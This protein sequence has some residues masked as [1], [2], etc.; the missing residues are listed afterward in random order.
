MHI[1]QDLSQSMQTSPV[2]F[3][4]YAHR[5]DAYHDGAITKLREELSNAIGVAIGEDF[6]I[7]QDRKDIAW[8]EHWP[9]KLEQGL[10]GC[11]FLIPI[12][13]PSFFTSK[14]CR[15]ELS[16]FLEIERATG[17]QDLILPIYFVST[18][19]L[20]NPAKRDD[21]PLAKAIAE[22]Q[23]RDW[24]ELRH[25]PF[26]D[27]KARRALDSLAEEVVQALER[28]ET[29]A[30]GE[31]LATPFANQVDTYEAGGYEDPAEFVHQAQDE[32][33]ME[34]QAPFVMTSTSSLPEPGTVFRDIEEPW[35]PE[36]VVIPSGSFV[37]GSPPNEE[38]RNKDE[39]PEHRVR[40]DKPFALG[41]YPITF[42]KFDHFCVE[43]GRRKPD[44]EGWGRGNEPV[45]NVNIEDAE[46]YLAWLSKEAGKAY[47]LPS[48]AVWEY[49]CR[50]G[51]TSPFSTGETITTNQANYN[52]SAYGDGKT[53]KPRD[54]TTQVGIF[55]ANSFGL[56]DM[57][58][59]VWE[60]CADHWH[61][62]YDGA[63]IDGTAWL[64]D[65][66]AGGRVV[67]G[68]A[69]LNEAKFLRS[70]QRAGPAPV[71]ELSRSIGF[72][73]AHIP[74]WSQ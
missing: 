21:D 49:A 59:N 55:P 34:Q 4:S 6:S 46:A 13:S 35:C 66:D 16:E 74:E 42:D 52:G 40:I 44:D 48:E 12:L 32:G 20:E 37:M 19:L 2:A 23:Y 73:C 31:A 27:Y 68:G 33:L 51:T 26:N 25:V 30:K 7:F 5:D 61:G 39:G 14:Y 54:Q 53:T 3:L 50:A 67:R 45:I 41:I 60:W 17:R 58:G 18:P 38:G 11:R 1:L 22:R 15:K 70:A 56:Y 64:D 62:S 36:M 10:A 65:G 47:S 43:T 28:S 71:K 63:P 9:S 24:R 69:W 29:E 8:G 57:H 72:R